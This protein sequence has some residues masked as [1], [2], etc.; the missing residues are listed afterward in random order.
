MTVNT[1]AK[2][3]PFRIRPRTEADLYAC[4][5]TRRRSTTRTRTPSNDD[6]RAGATRFFLRYSSGKYDDGCGS[7]AGLCACV[8]AYVRVTGP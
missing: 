3:A 4:V 8:A 7:R 6:G 1:P 5:R 2:T